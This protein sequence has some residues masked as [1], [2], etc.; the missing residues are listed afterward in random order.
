MERWPALLWRH[1]WALLALAASW[2]A[3]NVWL[4]LQA[5]QLRDDGAW[6][7]HL[8]IWS[9]WPL[10]IAMASGFA[11]RAPTQWFSDHPMFARGQ[12]SYPFVVN[13]ISGLLMRAGLGLDVAMTA[14]TLIA[15]VA[16]VFLLYAF[17]QLLLGSRAWALL[18][19]SLFYLG[20]GVGGLHFLLERVAQAD[21]SA[22]AYPPVEVSRLD[23]YDWYSGNAL[24]GMLL[25]QRAFVLGFALALASLLL[26]LLAVAQ[27][28]SRPRLLALIGG[29]LAGL[30][31]VVHTHS[32]LALAGLGLATAAL[33]PGAWRIWLAYALPAAG[34]GVLLSTAFLMPEQGLPRHLRWAPGFAADGGLRDWALMWWRL[35]GLSLPLAALGLGFLAGRRLLWWSALAGLLCFAFANLVLVQPNRWD[36]SK[37]FLWAWLCWTPLVVAALRGL[38]GRPPW[39]RLVALLLSLGVSTTG[40]VEVWRLAQTD[41]G[42]HMISDRAD[43]ELARRVRAGTRPDAVFATAPSHNHPVM[44][45]GGRP[46]LL[47]FTGWIANLGFDYAERE[48]ALADIFAGGAE[49]VD[50]LRRYRV[51]YVW[52]GPAERH[53]Y[54]VNQG[55]F[56]R[57]LP[58]AFTDGRTWVYAA[59]G[60]RLPAGSD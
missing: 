24:T 6:A 23:R 19:V 33:F 8:N 31:P 14:P 56:D 13:L 16:S 50:S 22:L 28:V 59:G 52:I 55:W 12:L 43:L 2:A 57:Q 39:G 26:L 25:P 15:A 48:Q 32:F 36:N 9:D 11:D 29:V 53:R 21:W 44:S 18:G 40:A 49:A 5:L 54:R 4:Q 41:R 46:I 3:L 34:L 27:R 17:M 51:D 1:R 7:G 20:A 10:H 38:Y 35:W 42:S 47:G 60:L 58:L 37:I 30:M 45:F